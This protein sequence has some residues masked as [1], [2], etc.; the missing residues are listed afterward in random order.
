MLE[1]RWTVFI[2]EAFVKNLKKI[3]NP[4]KTVVLADLDPDNRVPVRGKAQGAY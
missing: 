1:V 4:D 3:A 2:S